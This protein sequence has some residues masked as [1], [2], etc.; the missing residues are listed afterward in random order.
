MKK[1]IDPAGLGEAINKLK[2]LCL[3][4]ADGEAIYNSLSTL[5]AA[6]V[7]PAVSISIPTS[8]WKSGTVGEFTAYIDVAAKNVTAAD[9]VDVA[10]SAGSFA[11]TK[12]CGLCPTVETMNG[13]LRFRAVSA[14]QSAMTG[15]YRIIRGGEI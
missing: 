6:V 12:A 3:T 9:S 1:Y 15:E 11:T 10:L 2:S 13:Y 5:A 7:F 14:P 8:G 4:S